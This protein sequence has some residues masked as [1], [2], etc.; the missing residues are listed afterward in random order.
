MPDT[1]SDRTVCIG[2]E[3]RL[4]NYLDGAEDPAATAELA[5]HLESCTRC[6][7]ALVAARLGREL[8]REGLGPAKDPG[9]AFTTRVMAGI[10]ADEGRRQQF[11]RPLEVLA[12]RLALTAAAALLVLTVYLYEFGPASNRVQIS[13]QSQFSEG[14]PEPAAQPDSQDEVLL[15]LAGN[16]NGH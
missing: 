8:L 13:S 16:S 15:S 7:E 3:L 4:E 12:S 2:Y 1:R 11:W 10:R 5:A 14:L 9:A 6:R